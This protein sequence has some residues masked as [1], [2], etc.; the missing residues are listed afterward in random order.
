MFE[1]FILIKMRVEIIF[2]IIILI[3]CLIT[4]YINDIF[5]YLS[6]ERY[7]NIKETKDPVA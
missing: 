5:D 3:I 2:I 6:K 1:L 7:E 4:I